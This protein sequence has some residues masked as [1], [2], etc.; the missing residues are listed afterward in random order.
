MEGERCGYL[1]YNSRN[2][3]GVLADMITF[4][5]VVGIYNSR[6]Y[7]GVLADMEHHLNLLESTIVEIIKAY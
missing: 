7:K 1:I 4:V 2:Y 6:N 3:K 5:W